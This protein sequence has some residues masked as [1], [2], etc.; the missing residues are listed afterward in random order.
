MFIEF[1]RDF[2]GQNVKFFF[3]LQLVPYNCTKLFIVEIILYCEVGLKSF[4]V[5]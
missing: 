5:L 4:I 1:S 2:P 3:L